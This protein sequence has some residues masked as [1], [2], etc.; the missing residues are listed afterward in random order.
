MSKLHRDSPLGS[1]PV[2]VEINRKNPNQRFK[3]PGNFV[4]M[5]VERL[6][7]LGFCLV[8]RSTS[9]EWLFNDL[10]SESTR[11][12]GGQKS[13]LFKLG[14]AGYLALVSAKFRKLF[15][16]SHAHALRPCRPAGSLEVEQ[17]RPRAGGH[18]PPLAIA[19]HCRRPQSRLSPPM[20]RRIPKPTIQSGAGVLAFPVRCR[21]R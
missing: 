5:Q 20:S 1:S 3:R 8:A 16:S 7:E 18:R 19:R 13:G 15:W 12:G 11:M 2:H 21:L 10:F 6:Q 4:G 17:A 14:P 9:R